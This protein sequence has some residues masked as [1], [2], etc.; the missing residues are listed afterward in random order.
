MA[1]RVLSLFDGMSCGQLALNRA[2]VEYEE[3]LASEIDQFAMKVANYHF[4]KTNQLGDVKSINTVTVGSIDLLIGGS[5]CQGFSYAGKK[6]NFDDPRSVLFFEFVK[7][8]NSVKP[9]YFLFENVLMKREWI[10][11]I[12]GYLGVEPIFINSKLVSAQERKRLYWTNIPNVTVPEDRGITFE[13]VI[14]AGLYAGAMRGRRINPLTGARDDYNKLFEFKQYIECR[15]DNKSN[16]ISTVQKDNVVT[17]IRYKRNPIEKSEYRWLTMN[18]CEKLQTLPIG[19]TSVVSNTQR[20][21]MIGN[22]WTIDVIAHILENI[23]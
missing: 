23:I 13:D 20:L 1:L 11:V 8:L 2:G 9:K 7:M 21:K 17:K 18:E 14:G 19:Y 6:L 5:P 16:C 22:A 12:T 3:Y 15:M 10:N 4:P